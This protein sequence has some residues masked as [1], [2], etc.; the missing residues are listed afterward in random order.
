MFHVALVSSLFY[1]FATGV[2][3]EQGVISAK[4]GEES[5][6]GGRSCH[7]RRGHRCSGQGMCCHPCMLLRPKRAGEAE[8]FSACFFYAALH[9][10]LYT[11][12]IPVRCALCFFFQHVVHPV[13]GGGRTCAVTPPAE[14]ARAPACTDWIVLWQGMSFLIVSDGM[15]RKGRECRG[16]VAG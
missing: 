9:S 8:C 1:C 16:R 14:I 2:A 6:R 3:M 15:S 5:R 4:R 13:D 7:P 11:L 12:L 10:A